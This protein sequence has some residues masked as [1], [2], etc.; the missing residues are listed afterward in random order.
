MTRLACL[1]ALV[2]AGSALAV[3]ACGSG[4]DS[5]VP[6]PVIDAGGVDATRTNVGADA[7]AVDAAPP[8]LAYVRIAQ[9]NE[10]GQG[11][12]VCLAP[13]GTGAFAGPLLGA[14]FVGSGDAGV[15]FPWVSAYLPTAPGSYDVRFVAA[16]APDCTMPVGGGISDAGLAANAHLTLA[17]VRPTPSAS[18]GT[19]KLQDDTQARPGTIALRFV[20][21][22]PDH[23]DVSLRVDLQMSLFQGLS[24][25]KVSSATSNADPTELVVD[26]NGYATLAP[27]MLDTLY[28]SIPSGPNSVDIASQLTTI[29]AGSVVT[30]ALLP[31][32][33]GTAGLDAATTTMIVECFDNAG[34]LGILGDCIGPG[35]SVT[36]DGGM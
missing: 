7:S 18:S 20:D 26:P 30:A 5:A 25:A 35:I 23:S 6:A 15:P 24:Y 2:A 22:D 8:P 28:A 16:G 19:L 29:G 36:P 14:T 10:A 27:L 3:S 4:D 33:A 12:D 34:T 13:S 1:I 11:L 9:W 21:V 17:S 31:A 32:P